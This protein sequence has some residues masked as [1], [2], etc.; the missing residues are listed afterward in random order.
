MSLFSK[1][2]IFPSTYFI[3]ESETEKDLGAVVAKG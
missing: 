1:K 2:I 3:A